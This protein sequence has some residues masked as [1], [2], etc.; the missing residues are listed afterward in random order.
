MIRIGII[1]RKSY[2]DEKTASFLI[3]G[4]NLRTSIIEAGG[5]PF[6]LLPQQ[7]LN[8]QDYP[9]LEVPKITEQEKKNSLE[10][11]EMCDGIILPGGDEWTYLDELAVQYAIKTKTPILGICLGMQLMGIDQ[12][13]SRM[14]RLKDTSHKSKEQYVHDIKIRKDSNLYKIIEKDQVKVNSRHIHTIIPSKNWEISAI[15]KDGV[16]EAIEKNQHPF[17]IGLQW[18][19]EDLNDEISKKIFEIFVKACKNTKKE[20]NSVHNQRK[21]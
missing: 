19:P 10:L 9:M 8:Y 17:C 13:I 3:R 14:K 5:T 18:H 7:I 15:S 4:S 16:V 6:L 20:Y 2:D 11:L 1:A 21:E 12:E